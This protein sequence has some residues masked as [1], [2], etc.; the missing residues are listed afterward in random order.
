MGIIKE[1]AESDLTVQDLADIIALDD[2][3]KAGNLIEAS[4]IKTRQTIAM[5]LKA[6]L[7]IVLGPKPEKHDDTVREIRK[8]K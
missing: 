5:L 6:G 2:A 8:Y 7:D 4:K 3:M 1:R